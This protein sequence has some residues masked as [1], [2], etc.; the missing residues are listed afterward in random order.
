M[1]LP[2]SR[3]SRDRPDRAGRGSGAGS[4]SPGPG[5]P[6]T[7]RI[8]P[9]RASRRRCGHSSPP[10]MG[11][12][13]RTEDVAASFQEAVADVL[14]GKPI[15]AAE[16]GRVPR[17]VLRRWRFAE[18]SRL[19]DLA[20]RRGAAGGDRDVPPFEGAVHRQCGDGGAARRAPSLV[21]VFLR[22]TLSAYAAPGSP[23][24]SPR[25]TLAALGLSPRSRSGRT[26]SQNRN[27]AR[28][29]VP[30]LARSFPHRTWR[31]PPGLG[32]LTE[33][34]D[35]R[36]SAVRSA[37]ELGPRPGGAPLRDRFAGGS[38]G[39]RRGRLPQGLAQEWGRASR[40]E[41]RWSRTSRTPSPPPP[42]CGCIE[43]REVF[44]TA[45]S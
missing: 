41:G 15:E 45:R 25:R 10:R 39:D 11:R 8:S 38:R 29:I 5:F 31:S 36:G 30:A 21:G 22:T 3:R 28:K 17:L 23:A 26:S 1:G 37:V 24:D 43:L 13:A 40:P 6:A 19:R 33:L 14:V 35:G 32:A 9:S 27:V 4:T 20:Q 18:P 42:S 7:R 12:A 44:L 34:L 16:R 2:V